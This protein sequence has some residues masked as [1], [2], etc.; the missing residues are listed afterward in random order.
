MIALFIKQNNRIGPLYKKLLKLRENIQNRTKLL[1]F[2]R[3]KWEIFIQNYKK[4]LKWYNKFKPI[5]QSKY[6]VTTYASKGTGHKKQ[7]RNSL[8]KNVLLRLFYGSLSKKLFKKQIKDFKNKNATSNYLTFLKLFEKRLDTV[9]FRA[10]FGKS[11]RNARQLITHGLITVNNK[12]IT[13]PSYILKESDIIAVNPKYSLTVERNFK[14]CLRGNLKTGVKNNQ[15]WPLPPK[16]LLINYKTLEIIFGD[17]SISTFSTEFAYH[18]NLEKVIL[19]SYR[20]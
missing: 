9:L 4:K 11:L 8:N 19:N 3:K 17:I 10:K 5:D 14:Y 13:F 18:L 2:K 16:H 7:F 12:T 20:Q 6:L 15:L 1:K